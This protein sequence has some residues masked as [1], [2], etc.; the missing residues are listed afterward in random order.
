MESTV[1]TEEAYDFRRHDRVWQRVGSQ[2]DAYPP[3]ETTL[4]GLP[5]NLPGA[6]SDPCCMGTTAQ[7]DA[8]VLNGFLEDE[9]SGRQYYLSLLQIAPRWCRGRLLEMAND[10][11]RHADKLTAALYL[12]T[13]KIFRPQ[14]VCSPPPSEPW[15]EILRQAYHSEACAAM[16]YARAADE[17]PDFCLARLLQELRGDEYR[18]SQM[19][20]E[21]LERCL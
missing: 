15:R 18:H 17:T 10:E 8:A 16:N 6:Q 3:A 13:G 1:H 4:P 14:I 19:L 12:I 21:L 11:K 9:L 20:M 2:M 5:K 7:E